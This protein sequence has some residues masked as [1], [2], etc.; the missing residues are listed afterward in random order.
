MIEMGTRVHGPA[1]D[2]PA[3]PDG[4]LGAEATVPDT[5]RRDGAAEPALEIG[6]TTRDRTW[7]RRP[8]SSDLGAAG[9]S[10]AFIARLAPRPRPRPEPVP[11]PIECA[12]LAGSSW[13]VTGQ[14]VHVSSAFD[15]ARRHPI[16]GLREPHLG[17]DV[18]VRRG[19]AVRP[20]GPGVVTAAGPLG[21][22]GTR[23]IIDHGSGL[24]SLSHL[25]DERVGVGDSVFPG[26]TI[27]RVGASG[28]ATGV[29]LHFELTEYGIPVDPCE[30]AVY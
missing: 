16:S 14:D 23:V 9:E 5:A 15:P 30:A 24:Q 25:L 19:S 20:I 6:F 11:G 1:P 27:G 28:T 22:Y 8:D 26:D 18:V 17:V 13:P 3:L 10:R 4:P 12:R 21:G 29:H 2:E 7:V